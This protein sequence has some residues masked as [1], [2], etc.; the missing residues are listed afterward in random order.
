VCA[1]LQDPH[2]NPRMSGKTIYFDF[3]GIGHFFRLLTFE[4]ATGGVVCACVG[5]VT[6]L[7]SSIVSYP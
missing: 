1:V 7:R 6:L 5:V 2:V 3:Q 4:K